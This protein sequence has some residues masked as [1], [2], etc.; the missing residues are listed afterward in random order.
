MEAIMFN[1][2]RLVT[3]GKNR[4]AASPTSYEAPDRTLI[5]CAAFEYPRTLLDLC[6]CELAYPI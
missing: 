2:R 3:N 4:A 5:F 6:R 1:L